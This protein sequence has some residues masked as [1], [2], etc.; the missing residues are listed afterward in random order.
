[1]AFY[2]IY[3]TSKDGAYNSGWC[4]TQVQEYADYVEQLTGETFYTMKY[5]NLSFNA[6]D[7]TEHEYVEAAMEE[8]DSEWGLIGND[9]V[10]VSH[11]EYSYGYGG[12]RD[13]YPTSSGDAVGHAVYAG[14]GN[15]SWEV[16]LFVWH[17]LSHTYGAEHINGDH[18][19]TSSG[20]IDN[21]TPMAAAYCHDASG[22]PSTHWSAVDSDP[23]DPTCP[24]YFCY[25][26]SNFHYS[27]FSGWTKKSRHSFD[28]LSVCSDSKVKSWVNNRTS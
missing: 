17:E 8:I 4:W 18:T 6:G 24:S 7:K 14:S 13:V 19:V 15:T 27:G 25:G 21:V 23:N 12:G 26:Q 11:N 22:N 2:L 28:E 5:G 9:N 20:K 16:E 3:A 1:M 10:L